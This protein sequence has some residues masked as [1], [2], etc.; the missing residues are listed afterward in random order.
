M[1]TYHAPPKGESMADATGSDVEELAMAEL[2]AYCEGREE[3]AV[4]KAKGDSK[5]SVDNETLAVEVIFFI[6]LHLL[7]VSTLFV[8]N[9]IVYCCIRSATRRWW[10]RCLIWA[11][12]TTTSS[13]SSTGS[14]FC[15]C[16]RSSSDGST[17]RARAA[18]LPRPRALKFTSTSRRWDFLP[19]I[20][21]SLLVDCT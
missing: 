9:N 11:S 1:P 21:R 16:A 14:F 13:T 5:S 18:R 3:R 7:F 17:T 10:R 19:F 12:T 2:A 15:G 20:S 6:F 4:R 8:T